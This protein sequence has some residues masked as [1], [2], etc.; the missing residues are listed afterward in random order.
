MTQRDCEA[1]FDQIPVSIIFDV[2]G[3]TE[4][5]FCGPC[6]KG[7]IFCQRKFNTFPIPGQITPPNRLENPGVIFLKRC[8]DAQ[9]SSR[10][11][12]AH[13]QPRATPHAGHNSCVPVWPRSTLRRSGVPSSSIYP[14]AGPRATKSTEPRF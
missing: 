11:L 14:R 13:R 9:Q 8:K 7:N 12:G 6:N 1:D 2:I 10:A 5:F 4:L 3:R